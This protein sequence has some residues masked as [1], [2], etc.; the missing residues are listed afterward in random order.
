MLKR[1][2]LTACAVVVLVGALIY[3]LVQLFTL[4]F[5]RGDVYP[6]YSTFRADPLGAKALHDA[7]AES[8]GFEVQRNFRQQA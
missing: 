7:L 3:G 5:E 1:S 2:P 6:S 4:R 8:R